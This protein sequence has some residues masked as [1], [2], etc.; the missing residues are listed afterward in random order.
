MTRH[1]R[2]KAPNSSSCYI[3]IVVV[4]SSPQIHDGLLECFQMD[5]SDIWGERQPVSLQTGQHIVDCIGT[6]PTGHAVGKVQH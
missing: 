2:Q 3:F 5:M 1:F 6:L 4:H